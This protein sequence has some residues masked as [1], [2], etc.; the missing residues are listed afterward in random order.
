MNL[1]VLGLY[2]EGRTDERFLPIVIQRTTERILL[3]HMETNIEVLV[4][5]II[6]KRP[7]IGELDRCIFQAAREADGYHAL[8]IHSDTD[9]RTFDETFDQRFKPGYELV[10]QSHERIC[11]DLIP[12]IPVRMVEAWMLADHGKLK[13]ALNTSLSIRDLG[14]FDRLNQIEPCRDPKEKLKQAV[15]IAYPHQDQKW[16]RIMGEL[17]AELAPVI[18]LERLD[19]LYAYQRFTE[20]LENAMKNLG[21]ITTRYVM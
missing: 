16:H 14:L 6:K 7:D 12:V 18:S 13:E 21:I 9:S 17:Y 3:Q 19:R 10:K 20:D 8:I 5:I 11:K 2:A 1:L 4:P 15:K